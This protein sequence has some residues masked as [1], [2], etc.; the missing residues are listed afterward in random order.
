MI[1]STNARNRCPARA[2][3]DWHQASRQYEGYIFRRF[4]PKGSL[5]DKPISADRDNPI[6]KS[7]AKVAGCS[8]AEE[9]SAHSLRRGFATETARMGAFMASIQKH[10]RWKSTQT[11]LEYI[12][13]GREFKDSAVNVLFEDA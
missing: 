9:I 2:L 6:I 7:I 5:L 1:I 12:E 11:V 10:G 8:R 4:S 3:L 13:A